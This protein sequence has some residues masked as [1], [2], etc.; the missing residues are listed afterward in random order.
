MSISYIFS[1][2]SFYSMLETSL[3][4]IILAFALRYF[5]KKM[6]LYDHPLKQAKRR[7]NSLR[8]TVVKTEQKMLKKPCDST[9]LIIYVK[10]ISFKASL[11][12]SAFNLYLFDAADGSSIDALYD[13][14]EGIS[15]MV[16]E[17][18]YSKTENNVAGITTEF[19]KINSV[20]SEALNTVTSVIEC[21]KKNIFLNM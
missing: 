11:V 12:N 17:A 15:K 9:R 6:G 14:V 10:K 5:S 13:K 20:I 1:S 3:F 18:S 2:D 7:L 21:D 16:K 19:A 8:R 4:W